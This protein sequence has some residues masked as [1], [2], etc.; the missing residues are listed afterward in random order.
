MITRTS[1]LELSSWEVEV[2]YTCI[3]GSQEKV[4][5]P[6]NKHTSVKANA[7]R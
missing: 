5:R 3:N 1:S 6:I 4:N 7:N 2:G